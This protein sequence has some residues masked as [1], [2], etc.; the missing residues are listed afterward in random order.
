MLQGGWEGAPEELMVPGGET[1]V[2]FGQ[3]WACWA[4]TADLL[5]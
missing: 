4:Q 1:G 3:C 5:A 2:M